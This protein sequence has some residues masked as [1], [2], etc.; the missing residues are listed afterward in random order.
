MKDQGLSLSRLVITVSVAFFTAIFV[1]TC[2]APDLRKAEG[3]GE[4]DL[5]S[6]KSRD[7]YRLLQI[8]TRDEQEPLTITE[9]EMNTYLAK[10]LRGRQTG[11]QR[12]LVRYEGIFVDFREG[13]AEVIVVRRVLGRPLPI[14]CFIDITAGEDSYLTQ[15]QGT[16]IGRLRS[17]IWVID[18]VME[19][20]R[21]LRREY[22]PEISYLF[23][24]SEIRFEDGRMILDPRWDRPPPG[25]SP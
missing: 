4:G 17:R 12:L 2:R 1:Q 7:L 9:R 3:F 11:W 10:T 13:Q 22:Q 23:R 8:A 19:T 6:G 14:S 24:M 20:F 21:T 15:V 16:A 25:V 18:V 5:A